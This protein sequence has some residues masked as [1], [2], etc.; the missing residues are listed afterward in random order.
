M[1]AKVRRGACSIN[2]RSQNR[3]IHP[4]T[5]PSR[6]GQNIL[7]PDN[8]TARFFDPVARQ[9]N[10]CSAGYV[11]IGEALE[12]QELLGIPPPSLNGCH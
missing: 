7:G 5:Q 6:K 8:A 3:S 9:L 10:Q 2:G 12:F 4:A 11:P 1:A